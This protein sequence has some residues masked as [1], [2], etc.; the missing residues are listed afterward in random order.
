[1]APT[2]CIDL[3]M[4]SLMYHI[5]NREENPRFER[6]VYCVPPEILTMMFDTYGT[7]YLDKKTKL[8]YLLSQMKDQEYMEFVDREKLKT[9]STC[10]ILNQLRVWAGA[11]SLLKKATISLQLRCVEVPKQSN[12]TDYGVYVMKWI[13]LL[14]TTTLSGCYTFTCRY[15]IEKC[16][17]LDEFRKKIVSKLILSKENTLRV[18]AINQANK[19]GRQT[20]P[21]TA[22]KSP[23]VQISTAELGKKTLID[24]L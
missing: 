5:L 12:P 8:P 9:Y 14:D 13:V 1:M 17:Q 6:D 23:Y 3:Q 22:L 16:G 10:N 11:P 4:V 7:N 24:I 19:M 15:N 18:E 21:S 2:K 20:K